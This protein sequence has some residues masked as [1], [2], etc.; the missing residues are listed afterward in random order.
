MIIPNILNNLKKYGIFPSNGKQN[1]LLLKLNK[2]LID[3]IRI[4]RSKLSHERY[5]SANTLYRKIIKEVNIKLLRVLLREQYYNNLDNNIDINFIFDDNDDNDDNLININFFRQIIFNRQI[6]NIVKHAVLK[7]F[8]MEEEEDIEVLYNYLIDK[9]DK[10]DLRGDPNKDS[11]RCLIINGLVSRRVE[12]IDLAKRFTGGGNNI[13]V[14]GAMNDLVSLFVFCILAINEPTITELASKCINAINKSDSNNI[15]EK[16][17]EILND[18]QIEPEKKPLYT[19]YVSEQTIEK[20]KIK[21]KYKTKNYAEIANEVNTLIIS[22]TNNNYNKVINEIIDE[23]EKRGERRREEDGEKKYLNDILECKKIDDV[24]RDI[25]S[26]DINN[27]HL[28]LKLL[29]KKY[30]DLY[31]NHDLLNKIIL[32][33]RQYSKSI[34]S[35][36]LETLGDLQKGSARIIFGSYIQLIED[37]KGSG[38]IY[39]LDHINYEDGGWKNNCLPMNIP[40]DNHCILISLIKATY[41]YQQLIKTTATKEITINAGD[42]CKTGLLDIPS[43]VYTLKIELTDREINQMAR[44]Y[45]QKITNDIRGKAIADALQVNHA[46]PMFPPRR[47]R[48]VVTQLS[49]G[50][51]AVTR[52]AGTIRSRTDAYRLRLLNLSEIGYYNL[53]ECLIYYVKTK[54]NLDKFKE[55]TCPFIETRIND[56]AN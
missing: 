25:E 4:M 47:G 5:A 41:D 20:E 28:H 13:L 49:V 11:Q 16:I 53:D 54:P 10:L 21:N 39:K 7:K 23:G 8:T 43:N 14:G 44:D 17:N 6:R 52:A 30:I 38:I 42:S 46:L 56:M 12:F 51:E 22:I 9:L 31:R 48:G 3:E 50:N 1:I 27:I 19:T 26:I 18:Q 32:W 40:D 2:Q 15:K 36:T 24:I 34:E 35:H 37:D 55:E 45:E 33:L 29:D